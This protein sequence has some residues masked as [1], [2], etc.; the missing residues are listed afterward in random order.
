LS[1]TRL[2]G[3]WTVWAET[4]RAGDLAGDL[5]GAVH[6][7]RYANRQPSRH[8]LSTLAWHQQDL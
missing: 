1:N 8:N 3:C 6:S 5:A 7:G 4:T 2:R